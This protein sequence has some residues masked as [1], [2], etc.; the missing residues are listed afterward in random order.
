MPDEKGG[1]RELERRLFKSGYAPK[2]FLEKLTEREAF[3]SLPKFKIGFKSKV[4]D[5]FEKVKE[6]LKH[7]HLLSLAF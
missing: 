1:L 3:V 6:N 2:H 7:H 4:N 5:V